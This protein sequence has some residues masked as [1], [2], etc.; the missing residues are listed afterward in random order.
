MPYRFEYDRKHKIL[1]AIAWGEFGDDEQRRII[2]DIRKIASALGARAGI[3]DVSA[4]TAY[5]VSPAVMQSVAR[6]PS[7]YGAGVP[8]YLVAPSDI[9]FGMSR[10]YQMAG[11][12]TGG[13]LRVVRSRDD[14]LEELGARDAQF[15][16]VDAASPA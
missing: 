9:A 2:N 16:P 7:P 15:E 10:L 13:Q 3:G 4:V 1:L 11:E 6:G 12:K 5:R 14:A 8:R